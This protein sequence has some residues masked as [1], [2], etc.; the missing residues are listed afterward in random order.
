MGVM[1][2]RSVPQIKEKYTDLFKP[3]LLTNWQ[4]WPIAQVSIVT[5]RS[6]QPIMTLLQLINFR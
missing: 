2:G 3:A 1:E 5:L 6:Y 4:V